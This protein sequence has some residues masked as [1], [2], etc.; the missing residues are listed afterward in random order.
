MRHGLPSVPVDLLRVVVGVSHIREEV[1]RNMKCV[2]EKG[3]ME[4]GR[5]ET[6]RGESR[7]IMMKRENDRDREGR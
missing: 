1:N 5:E 2:R 3:I 7:K 6:E 4:K